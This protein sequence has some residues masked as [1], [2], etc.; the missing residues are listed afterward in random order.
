MRESRGMIQLLLIDDARRSR[1]ESHAA[2][3]TY[4]KTPG[5]R[6]FRSCAV[7]FCNPLLLFMTEQVSGWSSS[8]VRHKYSTVRDRYN[9]YARVCRQIKD[10]TRA[11]FTL[12]LLPAKPEPPNIGTGGVRTCFVDCS[13]VSHVPRRNLAH[14][15]KARRDGARARGTGSVHRLSSF[16]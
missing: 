14:G 11:A 12:L 1:P 2:A 5:T 16:S 6:P 15:A 7:L 10:T 8:L 9:R 13:A 4:T 3:G